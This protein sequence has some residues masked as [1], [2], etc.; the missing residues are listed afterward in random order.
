MTPAQL[1]AR[2][3]A[4]L[5]AQLGQ[6]RRPNGAAVP[7]LWVGEPPH[8]YVASGLEVRIEPIPEYDLTR[9]HQGIGI[10]REYQVRF[11]PHEGTTTTQAAVERVLHALDTTNPTTIPQSERLGILQQ[12]VLRVRS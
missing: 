10:G 2:L 4:L 7:A 6:Y 12:L 11:I 5:S 1:R 9:V 3:A 8:D